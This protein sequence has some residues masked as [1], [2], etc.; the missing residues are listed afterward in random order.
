MFL[1]GDQTPLS[2]NNFQGQPVSLS[3]YKRVSLFTNKGI[4]QI[5]NHLF[6]LKYMDKSRKQKQQE[7]TTASCQ[8]GRMQEQQHSTKGS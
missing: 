2:S 7:Q 1:V 5:A 6:N 3:E 8:G 4:D